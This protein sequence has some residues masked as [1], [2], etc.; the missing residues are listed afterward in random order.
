MR[1]RIGLFMNPSGLGST[2]IGRTSKL[3]SCSAFSSSAGDGSGG[4]RGRGRG[5]SGSPLYNFVAGIADSNEGLEDS[6]KSLPPAGRGHGSGMPLPSSP[7]LPSYNSFVA[8]NPPPPR[9]PGLSQG[10]GGPVQQSFEGGNELG[11]QHKAPVF[12][13]KDEFTGTSAEA[14]S[15]ESVPRQPIGENNLPENILNVLSGTGR[16]IPDRK[17]VFENRVKEENRHIR[18]KQVGAPATGAARGG[19]RAEKGEKGSAGAKTKISK[20]EAVKKAVGILSRGDDRR[21]AG[22]AERGGGHRRRGGRLK[23]DSDDEAEDEEDEDKLVMGDDADGEKLAKELGPSMMA[24]LTEAFEEMAIDV[25]PDPEEDEY[26]EAYDTNLKIELEPEYLMGD[27][28][29]NPDIYENPP[30]PLLEALEKM[31]PFLMAYEGIEKQEEWEEILNET[32]EKVPLLKEIVDHYCGPDRATA[33][34]QHEELKRVAKTIPANVPNSVK[35]FTD[36]AVLSLQSNP[37]W[38]FHRKWQ[39]MDKLALEVSKS[40][41]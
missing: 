10:R 1:G 27:F 12:L 24:E 3:V 40:C 30:I 33:K 7:F 39:F 16:G 26:L 32:M 6:D 31:K 5:V 4:G 20:E 17:P 28:E 34:Q 2:T 18:P 19:D 41:K 37:G 29:T 8:S 22:G 38:G 9:Q 35:N 13:K 15:V 11:S 21:E 36:R 23:A 14:E 25:L